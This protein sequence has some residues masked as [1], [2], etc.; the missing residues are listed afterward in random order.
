M[1]QVTPEKMIEMR[2]WAAAEFPDEGVDAYWT[3][4]EVMAAVDGHCAGGVDAWTAD[5]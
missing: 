1:S 3:D 5:E 2:A 4:E